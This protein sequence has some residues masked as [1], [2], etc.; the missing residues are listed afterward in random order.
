[1]AGRPGSAAKL[2]HALGF[3][4]TSRVC[5]ASPSP[6]ARSAPQQHLRG[7]PHRSLPTWFPARAPA[8]RT[9]TD[10]PARTDDPSAERHPTPNFE[11]RPPRSPQRRPDRRPLPPAAQ[12]AFHLQPR[13]P[14]VSSRPGSRACQGAGDKGCGGGA[15]AARTVPSGPAP[16]PTPPARA[17]RLRL[18][19]PGV[20]GR[21]SRAG[22]SFSPTN[23]GRR[24][25]PRPRLRPSAA[26]GLAGCRL[27]D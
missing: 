11:T 21:G 25:R 27:A 24:R 13:A 9:M 15:A 10:R 12:A 19:S 17:P 23:N 16:P 1:M 7:P 8:H 2:P 22:S 5:P 3:R 6:G 4:L 20:L 14:R 18:A 26:P